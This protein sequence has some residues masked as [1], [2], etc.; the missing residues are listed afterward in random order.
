MARTPRVLEVG[1]ERGIG[2]AGAAVE[3]VVFQLRQHAKPLGITLEIEEV[4]ALVVAHIIQPA[5]SC[6]LLEPVTDGVFARVA[7]RWVADVVGQAG[8]LHDH[9]Q[10][11]RFA[12]V[13]QILAQGF[14]YAHA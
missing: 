11:A 12:P 2:Q 5:A 1:A 9:A 8:G 6:C 4:G 13:G 14:T 3:L 7:E 10:V